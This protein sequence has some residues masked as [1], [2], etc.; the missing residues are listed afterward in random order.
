MEFMRRGL[1]KVFV[2]LAATS[3]A[4]CGT[5]DDATSQKTLTQEDVDSLPTGNASGVAFSGVY[6][7]ENSEISACRC[8]VGSCDDWRGSKGDRFTLTQ[9][10]GALMLI[11]RGQYSEATYHGG[12]DA[13]GSFLVGSILVTETM[14]EYLLLTGKVVAATSIDARSNVTHAGPVDGKDYD[15]DLTAELQLNYVGPLP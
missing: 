7:L 3:V 1:A 13:D 11:L 15:C 5:P 10:D 12:I 14:Q 9:T 8:R 4:G 6:T 2:C